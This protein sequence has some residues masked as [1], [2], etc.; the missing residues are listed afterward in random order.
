MRRKC[1]WVAEEEPLQFGIVGLLFLSSDCESHW[2]RDEQMLKV[3]WFV[4]L[5]IENLIGD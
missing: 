5:F 2:E 3:E 4:V 1:N